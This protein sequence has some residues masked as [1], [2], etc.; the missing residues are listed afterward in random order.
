MDDR[1]L[2]RQELTETKLAYYKAK[3]MGK[4]KAGFL[5]RTAHE[6]RSPLASIVSLHQL[7]L[8]D[9][10]EN[11]QEERDFVLQA[12]QAALKLTQI[13]DRLIFISKLEDGSIA[14]DKSSFLLTDL[15]TEIERTTSLQAANRNIKLKFDRHQ[16]DC[17]AIGDCDCL[18]QMV[19][20]LIESAIFQV[21]A[22]EISL[23]AIT[24]PS[25]ATV[26]IE[27]SIEAP[28]QIWL[29]SV[30]FMQKKLDN[31]IKGNLSASQDRDFDLSP[32]MKFL[33]AQQL[34][35][36]MGGCLELLETPT[37]KAIS[38]TRLSFTLPL[39]QS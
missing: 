37:E 26:T 23:R 4:F 6:L 29:E 15:L 8:T 5:A 12:N 24:N 3:E 13:L 18:L 35:E 34:L 32:G 2:L 31:K 10:C 21:R 28:K 25:M 1:E 30:D 39:A 19:T 9:L 20:L 11:P 16:N 7:I 14:I 22:E 27:V 38:L 17:S 36:M 33:L